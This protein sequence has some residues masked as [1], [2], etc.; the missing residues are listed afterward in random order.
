M[1]SP[2]YGFSRGYMVYEEADNPRAKREVDTFTCGHCCKITKVKPKCDPAD[3]GGLCRTCMR[4]ICDR[5][6]NSMRCDPLEVKLERIERR[7][8]ALRSYGL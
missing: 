8:I 5:C 7:G 3:L 6:V 2:S 1:A 4:L